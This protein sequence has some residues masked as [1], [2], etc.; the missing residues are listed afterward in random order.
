M[1]K[2][3]PHEKEKYQP[4][5][6]TTIL[7]EVGCWHRCFNETW[8]ALLPEPPPP[9]ADVSHTSELITPQE[10]QQWLHRNRF[11]TF[12]RLF[13]NFSGADL[14]KL[15]REDV[16]QICGPADGIRLFNALKGRY[17][18]CLKADCGW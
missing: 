5:Y 1:E 10:A 8:L 14:L 15:T 16:I 18:V 13:R 6:E 11:S 4:S 12:S 3:T 2:R 17:V 9:I 7:T